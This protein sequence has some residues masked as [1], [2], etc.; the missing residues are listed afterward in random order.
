MVR[1]GPTQSLF[2]Y[3]RIP[4]FCYWCGMVDD[5]ER[6]CLRWVSNKETL[7]PED[8]QFGL[9]L[10]AE[11]DCLQ[12]PQV[13]RVTKEHECEG[14]GVSLVAN[15]TGGRNG[16]ADKE[17]AT[18]VAIFIPNTTL[19]RNGDDV[20]STRTD[21]ELSSPT[22][23]VYEKIPQQISSNSNFLK[24]LK[25]IDDAINGSDIE[26]MCDKESNPSGGRTTN[27]TGKFLRLVNLFL[28]MWQF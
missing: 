11:L 23:M 1:M 4:I 8:K 18:T 5:D 17:V 12:R 14:R 9:W 15:Q 28:M 13:V 7:R 27:L 21:T 10:R 24:E 3:E 20:G 6:D 16:L 19:A 26:G 22:D 25:E 2:R